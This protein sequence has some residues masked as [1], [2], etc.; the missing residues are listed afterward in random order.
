MTSNA[1][2][3]FVDALASGRLVLDGGLGTLLEQ[4]G[5][6]VSGELWSARVLLDHPKQVQAAHEAFFRAG[7]RVAISGSYQVGYDNLGAAGFSRAEVDALLVQSVRVAQA[8]RAASGF[9]DTAWVAASVGPYGA[10]RADG[11]E[12]TGEYGL[13]EDELRDWHRPRLA[14]LAASGADALAAETIPSLAEVAAL[15]AE[16]ESLAGAPPAWISVTIDG[17]RLRSGESLSE[18]FALAAAS[19]AVAAIGVNC[20]DPRDVLGA[21]QIAR[22]VTD[23]P[24][25]AYPNSGEQWDAKNRRWMGRSG[26]PVPMVR[27]WADAGAAVVGGCCRVDADAVAAIGVALG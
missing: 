9:D 12:Y 1:P 6:D 18:A 23:K 26:V 19:D 25:I 5:S 3:S 8:A 20:C 4:R 27:S 14:V 24:F 7:A 21:V 13:S 15:V 17:D 10:T 16:L 11:S 22:Y 2:A